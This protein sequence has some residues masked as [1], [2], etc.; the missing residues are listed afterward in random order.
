MSPNDNWGAAG[1]AGM[2]GGMP[3]AM[4]MSGMNRLPDMSGSLGMAGPTGLGGVGVGI[5]SPVMGGVGFRD[6]ISLLKGIYQGWRVEEM[7]STLC[8]ATF[9][10]VPPSQLQSL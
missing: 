9:A 1:L 7:Q 2:G 3:A 10:R 4:G 8:P 6:E 5:Q